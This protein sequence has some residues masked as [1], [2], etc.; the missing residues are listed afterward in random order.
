M[1][2]VG[3]PQSQMEP[4]SK[5]RQRTEGRLDRSR[6]PAILDAALA[7]LAEHGY[8][9]TNMND[10]AARAGVGK[11]AIYRRW[12]SKAAL[13]T[14]ALIY[15]RPELLNDD[16]PDTGSLAG[17]LDAIVKRAKRNDNALISNDL[18]LR[19]ALEAAHDPELATALNDLIL[20]KG[21][22]VLSAVLAQAADRGEIDPNRDWS[23]VADVLTAMGLLRAI[24]GQRVDGKFVGRVIDTLILPAVRAAPE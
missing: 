19:V 14:D 18:V 10:I 6:D 2:C 24:S 17:D 4:E 16:A 1:N 21:R 9:A 23:L 20:F 11:A 3:Q 7:A 22:R 8:D 13:M 15:W 5:L 12:S